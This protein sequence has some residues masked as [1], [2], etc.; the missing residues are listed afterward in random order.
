MRGRGVC[1]FPYSLY[2]SVY[3]IAPVSVNVADDLL[4]KVSALETKEAAIG[5]SL[6]LHT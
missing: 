5:K 2:T 4:S 1:Q 3:I 6:T